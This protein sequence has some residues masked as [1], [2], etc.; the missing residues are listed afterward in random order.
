MENPIT[1]M[2]LMK[3]GDY[4]I[5]LD[6]EKAYHHVKVGMELM[7]YLGF[8]FLRRF[9]TYIGMPF[10]WNRSPWIFCNLMK[11]TV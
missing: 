9:Y 10:G 1:V 4:G 2:E 3:Q 7:K 6:L 8:K 5:T 11:K